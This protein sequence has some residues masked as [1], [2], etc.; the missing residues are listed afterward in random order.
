M[1][2]YK[3]RKVCNNC[4][5][6]IELLIPVGITVKEYLKGKKCEICGCDL[7]RDI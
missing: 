6:T 3:T 4:R 5:N 2:K 7:L 1:A